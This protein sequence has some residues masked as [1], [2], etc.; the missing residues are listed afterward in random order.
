MGLIRTLL[1]IA[2]VYYAIKFLAKLFAP[3]L[4]KY[5]ANKMQDQFDKQYGANTKSNEPVGKTTVVNK[6]NR[7]GDIDTKDTGEY[8]DYEE[9]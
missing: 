5:A 8:I 7:N 4:Q 1:I 9:L 2:L 3:S 6:P